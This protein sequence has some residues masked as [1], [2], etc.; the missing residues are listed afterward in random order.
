MTD[1][2]DWFVASVL[3]LSAGIL[4]VLF[5]LT[6]GGL[7]LWHG[8]FERAGADI[9]RTLDHAR[10]ESAETASALAQATGK[11]VSEITASREDRQP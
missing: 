7:Y 2:F 1:R 11:A 8:S 9:D 4:A 6:M 10:R 3:R 5:V